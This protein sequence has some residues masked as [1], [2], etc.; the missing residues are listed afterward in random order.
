[1]NKTIFQLHIRGLTDASPLFSE[2]AASKFTAFKISKSSFYRS[3]SSIFHSSSLPNLLHIDHSKFNEVLHSA[4]S[5]NQMFSTA[6]QTLSKRIS[7]DHEECLIE[8]CIFNK[9]VTKGDGGAVF[10]KNDAGTLNISKTLF[11][12]NRAS[13][14][15]GSIYFN[16]AK[17]NFIQVCIDH[18]IADERGQTFYIQ[19]SREDSGFINYT[20]SSFCAPKILQSSAYNLNHVGGA[21]EYHNSNI[22]KGLCDKLGASIACFR[23]DI[24]HIYYT[25]ICANKGSSVLNFE[26]GREETELKFCNIF[27]NTHTDPKSQILTYSHTTYIRECIIMGNE[28]TFTNE[29][30]LGKKYAIFFEKCAYDSLG[31]RSTHCIIIKESRDFDIDNEPTYSYQQQAMLF[32]PAK[33]NKSK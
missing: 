3:F 12:Y 19:P 10:Y 1:M 20:T 8:G 30:T 31:L 13:E 23:V 28:K 7:I 24:K 2:R 16:G 33:E 27:N 9:C 26:F 15:G 29:I 11:S 25:N 5:V 32:C 18:C 21:A 22:T 14:C 17:Y 4:I 6:N